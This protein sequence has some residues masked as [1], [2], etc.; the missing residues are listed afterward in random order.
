[1]AGIFFSFDSILRA[2]SNF[3]HFAEWAG[4]CIYRIYI[5]YLVAA[6]IMAA[7][8]RDGME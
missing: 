1:M 7:K 3:R 8:T 4:F 5:C 6:V 2:E